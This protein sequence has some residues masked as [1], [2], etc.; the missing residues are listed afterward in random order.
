MG[1]WELHFDLS[2][3]YLSPGLALPRIGV[4]NRGEFFVD[5]R[6]HCQWILRDCPAEGLWKEWCT[7]RVGIL[8]LSSCY[9]KSGFPLRVILSPWRTFD[10]VWTRFWLSQLE[11]AIGIQCRSQGRRWG[12]SWAPY[13]AQDS[14]HSSHPTQRVNSAEVLEILPYIHS[15]LISKMGVILS[16]KWGWW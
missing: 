12:C 10:N 2:D 15:L 1:G 13:S 16:L 9:L 5:P 14:S 3:P 8:S 6:S 7:D 11:G 4:D